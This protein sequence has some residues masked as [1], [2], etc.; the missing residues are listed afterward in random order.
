[1]VV[2]S[3]PS[4]A[5]CARRAHH[6]RMRRVVTLMCRSYLRSA[7]H[8]C[9]RC[10]QTPA[11]ARSLRTF[12]AR[13]KSVTARLH[14]NLRPWYCCTSSNCPRSV[15]GG[16]QQFST[17]RQH[18]DDSPPEPLSE[19]LKAVT[20]ERPHIDET[21]VLD[22]RGTCPTRA[23]LDAHSS[24]APLKRPPSRAHYGHAV[25]LSQNSLYRQIGA[26]QTRSCGT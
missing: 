23:S 19:R 22:A 24:A 25:H 12:D 18:V 13:E 14:S 7:S 15:V 16:V 21:D 9:T 5:L 8:R 26:R 6:L 4:V 1:M 20:S 11:P 17:V 3:L 2:D 10:L